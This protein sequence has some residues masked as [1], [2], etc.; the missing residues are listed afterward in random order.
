MSYDE[1]SQHDAHPPE[2]D[3]SLC[4]NPRFR[5]ALAECDEAI[6]D[7]RWQA[8]DDISLE[9]LST[10]SLIALR[11]AAECMEML[12]RVVEAELV[13]VA[14][15]GG[16]PSEG[17]RPGPGPLAGELPLQKVGRFQLLEQ[18]GCGAFGIVYL[19]WDPATDREVAVKIP[20]FETLSSAELRRRFEQEARAAAKLDHPNIVPVLEA[21]SEGSIP[22]IASQY[23]PGVSLSKW[24]EQHPGMTPPSDAAELVYALADGMAHAHRRGVLHRDIKPSN[25]LLVAK[26]SAANVSQLCSFVPKLTDFGLAK[27]VGA[28]RDFTRTGAMLGTLHYM[29][30]E[31]ATGRTDEIGPAADVYS[32]GA[33]LYQLL[34]GKTPFTGSSD[35]EILRRIVSDEPTQIRQSSRHVPVDLETICLKCLE[36]EPAR[37][38]SNA[39]A[40]ADDLQRYLNGLPIA[41]R[42]ATAAERLTKWMRRNPGIAASIG[43]LTLGLL[44]FLTFLAWSNSRLSQA[45]AV[46][47]EYAYCADM[48][49][50]QEAWDRANL[51]ETK[52]LLDRYVPRPGESDIRRVEW[53]LLKRS[54]EQQSVIVAQQP[55]PIWSLAVS[56]KD[57]Y[58]ATGDREGKIR[59]W[60]TRPPKLL[61]TIDFGGKDIDGLIFAERSKLLIGIGD[62]PD[63]RI[64]RTADGQ[65]DEVLE[66]DADWIQSIALSPGEQYLAIGDNRGRIV[67]WDFERRER[68]GVLYEEED[69]IRYL[70]FHPTLP[71]VISVTESLIRVWDYEQNAHPPSIADGVLEVSNGKLWHWVTVTPRG[72]ALFARTAEHLFEWS[73]ESESLGTLLRQVRITD[74]QTLLQTYDNYLISAGSKSAPVITVRPLVDLETMPRVLR[75]HTDQIRGIASLTHE[76]AFLTASMDGTVRR[77]NID[78]GDP[79]RTQVHVGSH[80]QSLGWTADGQSLLRGTRYGDVRLHADLQRIESWESLVQVSDGVI[81]KV[82]SLK[83][84]GLLLVDDGGNVWH[85]LPDHMT[86]APFQLPANAD[87]LVLADAERIVCCSFDRDLR[88][89]ELSSGK[90]LWET[91]LPAGINRM[92]PH[93]GELYLA[94]YD[95]PIRCYDV[96]TG[97]LLRR[98]G[99]TAH[100]TLS[101]D[102]STNGRLLVAIN[103]RNQIQMYDRAT[104]KLL[105]EFAFS[106]ELWQVRFI[107]Q[108][109]RLLILDK[110][111]LSIV[112]WNTGQ[113]VY[114]IERSFNPE[115]FELSPDRTML[116]SATSD[117]DR[118]DIVLI[119][120]DDNS[121]D[122]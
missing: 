78:S 1:G 114:Q 115:C 94:G 53:R 91:K 55:T 92:V 49:L 41:A 95:G 100:A 22:Y 10:D 75:G 20:R 69:P 28:E 33:L 13:T 3:E 32:L 71:L 45:L 109:Q 117:P 25:V 8:L 65:L 11:K 34:T 60:S 99:N 72:T 67:L 5:A 57:E 43:A 59:L 82:A 26:P 54:L 37:R 56:E 121:A 7:G 105:N 93:A 31:Q 84:G 24:L 70:T 17:D 42:R 77:W 15:I 68:V 88:V 51:W 29:P 102:I 18:L 87:E 116:V 63:V 52:R 50:A 6:A 111:Y 19:G 103:D 118:S 106:S 110:R 30:P 96:R 12:H 61:R 14:D 89:A 81:Q 38:Y 76:R 122:E 119:R 35:L 107:D 58:I 101:L 79:L 112:N 36:K 27:L 90:V 2:V 66:H 40:L 74:P 48:R 86:Q 73:M 16:L 21:N 62:C 39:S 104:L 98:T 97:R 80:N 47:R 9:E 85:G 120:L 23:C 64:W 44:C 4:D 113:V 83:D 108:D 46:A